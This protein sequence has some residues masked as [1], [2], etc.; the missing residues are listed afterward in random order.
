MTR[1]WYEVH[2]LNTPTEWMKLYPAHPDPEYPT[3]TEAI[4]FAKRYVLSW[5]DGRQVKVL[6]VE[7]RREE[8]V[9]WA[10]QSEGESIFD[11]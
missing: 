3:E 7:Q 6:R 1:V 9:V 5:K 10:G 11:D 8:M 4:D 2:L